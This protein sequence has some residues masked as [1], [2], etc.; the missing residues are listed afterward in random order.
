MTPFVT[1][2][3]ATTVV[4]AVGAVPTRPQLEYTYAVQVQSTIWIAP[5]RRL[6]ERSEWMSQ[7]N[8]GSGEAVQESGVRAI[9][10]HNLCKLTE[11][12]LWKLYRN[13]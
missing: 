12:P 8:R 13:C 7:S 5:S 2:E 11:S 3:P 9:A 1:V 6:P 10:L 4:M